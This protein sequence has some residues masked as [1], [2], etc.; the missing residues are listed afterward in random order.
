VGLTRARLASLG[1]GCMY[2]STAMDLDDD[3][4]DDGAL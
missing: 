2:C 1:L 4:S 3:G